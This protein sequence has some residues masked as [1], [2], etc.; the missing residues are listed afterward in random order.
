MSDLF[1]TLH[2]LVDDPFDVRPLPPGEVR[3]RGD[4][5]RRRRIALQAVA[6]TT[7]MAMIVTVATLLLS[8][9]RSSSGV[10]PSNADRIVVTYT[11]YQ[12]SDRGIAP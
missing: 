8:D 2:T 7:V 5:M 1:D 10:A 4:R 11:G 3:R 6:L 9:A 12:P